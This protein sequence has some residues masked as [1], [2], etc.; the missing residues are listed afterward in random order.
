MAVSHTLI[1]VE[2]PHDVE[3]VGRFLA[4]ERLKRVQ[5]EKILDPFWQ[6]L[7]PP[8]LPHG[9]DLLKRVP[10]PAFF[11]SVTQ[12]VAVH[13]AGGDTNIRLQLEADLAA[14]APRLLDGIGV[15]LDADLETA[16]LDRHR[17]LV[18]S[19]T[20]LQWPDTPG[21]VGATIPK[22]G[23]F[24]LPD[25]ASPGNLETVLL[26]CA[27]VVYPDLLH[28]AEQFTQAAKATADCKHLASPSE[29][30]KAVA[31]CIANALRPGRA[32]QTSIHDNDW[33]SYRTIDLPTISG[34]RAFLRSLIGFD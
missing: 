33:V 4:M 2:G 23:V 30:N 31:G 26:K 15:V 32:M 19:I 28:G 7:I 34:F 24:V 3:F 11:E 29:H 21:S 12:S 9:G 10:V 1:V 22:C 20:G 5:W 18:A 27:E 25:N 14:L 16:A 13:S 8:T 17:D 6:I